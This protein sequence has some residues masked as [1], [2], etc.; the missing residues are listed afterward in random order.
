MKKVISIISLSALLLGGCKKFLDVNKDPNNPTDV[1]ESLLLAPI[2]MNISDNIAGGFGALLVQNYLQNIAPNQANPGIANYQLFSVDVNGDWTMYYVNCLNNLKI[3][4][5]KAESENHWNYA[6]IAKI[7]SAYVLGNAT[8]LWGDIPYSQAFNRNSFLVPYDKQEDIYKSIQSLLNN[9]IADISKGDALK[10]KGDDYYYK[11]NMDAWRKVAYSLKARYFMHLTKAPGYTAAV[12]ADSALLALQNGMTANADDW[13]FVYEGAASTENIWY[14][15]FLPVTTYVLNETII[16]TLKGRNDPR[17]PVIAKPAVLSGNYVGRR[18]G[19]LP[20]GNL[21]AYSYLNN[22]YGAAASSNYIY[23]YSEAVFLKAE[24]VLLKSGFAAAQPVYR[25]G[26]NS[27]LFKLGIDTTSVAA[28]TYVNSRALT[29]G[30]ALQRIME[31]KA[32]ANFLNLETFND[33]RRT[34][35][36]ALTPVDGALS[37]IPRRLLYPESELQSN[38]QPQQS[39]VTLTSRV[40]WDVQ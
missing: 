24:A 39:G 36:P 30:N 9:A 10:P 40:W 2:E 34:G 21:A 23:N 29:A 17:L 33:W 31:E 19:T 25:H 7:L 8:D 4:N 1:Q 35:F 15:T 22:F 11:G 6:A 14:Y 18:V 12:Q 3:L 28:T 32:V 20:A 5:Q 38:E 27:H 26:I 37:A 13:K 16:E